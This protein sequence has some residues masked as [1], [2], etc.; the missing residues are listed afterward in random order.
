MN[1]GCT[2]TAKHGLDLPLETLIQQRIN[3]RIY[4]WIKHEQSVRNGVRS[5]PKHVDVVVAQDV[6]K[7]ASNP[8]DSKYGTD[9]DHTQSDSF[10]N[11]KDPLEIR[12][13]QI[14]NPVV[15][16]PTKVSYLNY[17]EISTWWSVQS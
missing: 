16:L 15:D 8:T 12:R 6:N 10:P 11:L 7:K 13:K 4:C 5:V 2:F 14:T 9:S 3:K 1:P 17:L